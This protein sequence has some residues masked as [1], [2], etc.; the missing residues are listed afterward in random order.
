MVGTRRLL[1]PRVS[2]FFVP[3]SNQFSANSDAGSP[4]ALTAQDICRFAETVHRSLQPQRVAL[5]IANSAQ[6]LT[7][8]DRVAVVSCVGRRSVVLAV[9]S[10]HSL[11]KQSKTLRYLQRAVQACRPWDQPLLYPAEDKEYPPPME[12]SLARYCDESL[13]AS[14]FLVPMSIP[15]DREQVQS[16]SGAT[17]MTMVGYLVLENFSAPITAEIQRECQPLARHAALALDNAIQCQ[18]IPLQWLTGFVASVSRQRRRYLFGAAVLVSLA[19]LLT[20]VPVEFTIP[21]R[22]ILVPES[23]RHVYAID[24]GVI[25][26]VD[27]EDGQEIASGAVLVTLHNLDLD[28]QIEEVMGE[29]QVKQETLAALK[30]SRSRVSQDAAESS[31]NAAKEAETLRSIESLITRQERLQSRSAALT[32]RSPIDGRVITWDTVESL[33]GRPVQRGQHLLD[34]IDPHSAWRAEVRIAEKDAAHVLL[35]WRSTPDLKSRCSLVSSSNEVYE[36]LVLRVGE[37]VL[38]VDGEDSNY[39]PVLVDLSNVEQGSLHPGLEVDVVI[40]CG[41]RPIG[42][43][44]FRDLVEA[45][46]KEVLFRFQ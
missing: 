13:V 26:A 25:S 19:V 4:T 23:R 15:R 8:V 24:D 22:G 16:D 14:A 18:Q 17:S 37:Q 20:M 39:L 43:V 29:I 28:L 36:G 40:R 38:R 12:E 1:I 21:A 11:R 10:T 31:D 7:S 35:A 34:V 27:V 44:L 2:E 3:M 30:A 9:S 33:R 45:L 32:I 6:A 5:S 41:Q 42:F 46:R